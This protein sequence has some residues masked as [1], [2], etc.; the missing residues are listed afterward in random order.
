MPDKIHIKDLELFCNHGVFPEETKLGQKFLLSLTLYTD[1]REAGRTDDLTKS[2][3]YGD[4]SHMAKTYLQEHTFFPVRILYSATWPLIFMR[5]SKS[6]T[7][8]PSIRSI[9]FLNSV[10]S[11]MQFSF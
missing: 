6:R 5:S 3:H 7:I 2:I 9:S 10:K 11:V 1:I 8:S 4:V